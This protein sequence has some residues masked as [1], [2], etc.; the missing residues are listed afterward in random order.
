MIQKIKSREE[1]LV[2]TKYHHNTITINKSRKST[3]NKMDQIWKLDTSNIITRNNIP[4]S[5][6]LACSEIKTPQGLGIKA[7]AES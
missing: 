4:W 1:T 5:E 6:N 7:D 3:G 2:I